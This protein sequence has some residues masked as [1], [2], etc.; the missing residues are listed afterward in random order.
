MRAL[1]VA[2]H[3]V[4]PSTASRAAELRDRVSERIDGPAC[5]LVVPRHRGRE[6]WRS[7]PARAWLRGRVAAGDEVVAHG[8]THTD[9]GGRDG[10]ELAGRDAASVGRL[11]ADSVDELDAA[12]LEARGF[13]A[14]SYAHPGTA[15]AACRDAGLGWWA[16]RVTLATPEARRPLPSIGLGASSPIRRAL[17]PGAAAIAA[18][19]LAR[20]PA[21]R[22]DLHPADLSHRRLDRAVGTLLDALAGQGR[23]A[24]TH[25]ELLGVS[26]AGGGSTGM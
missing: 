23:R 8:Y 3:D 2:I 15:D 22:L 1:V 9:R 10:R 16:T 13:I 20:A 11:I 7:G 26:A 5:L 24:V 19:A 6:S 14:P 21:V 12:G 17:S 4:S 18:R 25:E